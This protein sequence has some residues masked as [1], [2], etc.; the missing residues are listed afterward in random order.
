MGQKKQCKSIPQVSDVVLYYTRILEHF[1]F[2]S[3]M[4][5]KGLSKVGGRFYL[6]KHKV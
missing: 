2:F 3:K 5:F 1:Y 4:G 6:L